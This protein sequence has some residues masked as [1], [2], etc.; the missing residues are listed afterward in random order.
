V[1]IGILTR[2]EFGKGLPNDKIMMRSTKQ[3]L[4][5]RP[6]CHTISTQR[7]H[8]TKHSSKQKLFFK[9]T[10]SSPLLNEWTEM[11]LSNLYLS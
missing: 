11:L 3:K 8:K 2:F 10:F 4:K 1:A 7:C 9:K 6:T 5:S